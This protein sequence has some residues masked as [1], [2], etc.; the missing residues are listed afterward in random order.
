VS[1]CCEKLVAEGGDSSGTPKEEKHPRLEA[2][3]KQRLVKTVPD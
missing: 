2:A 3:I 1:C